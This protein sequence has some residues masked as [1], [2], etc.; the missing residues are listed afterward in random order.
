LV[1]EPD[2]VSLYALIIDLNI[3]I[4]LDFKKPTI[5]RTKPISTKII[6][7]LIMAIYHYILSI[8]YKNIKKFKYKLIINQMQ[9]HLIL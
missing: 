2:V 6:I 1:L 8:L 5:N 4:E 3:G 9:D 7:N